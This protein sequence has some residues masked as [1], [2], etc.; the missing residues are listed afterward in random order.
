MISSKS[1]PCP[2]CGFLTL[3]EPAGSGTFDICPVCF[4]E[5]DP[6]QLQRPESNGGANKV[7][8]NEAKKNFFEFGAKE[9]R[10]IP[11]VRKPTPEEIP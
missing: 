11:Y 2:C 6:F 4:W 10:V 8:L 3:I 9:K 5:D 7:S 1:Y